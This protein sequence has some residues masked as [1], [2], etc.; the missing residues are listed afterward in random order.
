MQRISDSS[1]DQQK[2]DIEE[3]KLILLGQ[4]DKYCSDDVKKLSLQHFLNEIY[5]DTD[6]VSVSSELKAF[7]Q[8]HKFCGLKPPQ[9]KVM[10]PQMSSMNAQMH[11]SHEYQGMLSE[12]SGSMSKISLAQS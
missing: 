12:S 2:I 4:T 9:Q 3:L 6:K 5:R 1:E 10:Q 8:L 11:G 7:L